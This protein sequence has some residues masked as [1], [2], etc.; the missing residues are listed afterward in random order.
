MLQRYLT[1]S[2]HCFKHDA[3]GFEDNQKDEFKYVVRHS[4]SIITF[5][6]RQNSPITRNLECQS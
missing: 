3:D 5:D 6:S 2:I 4:G 1:L